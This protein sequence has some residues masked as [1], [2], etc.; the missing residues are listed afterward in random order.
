MGDGSVI[1]EGGVYE[2]GTVITLA[3]TPAP[4]WAFLKWVGT[5]GDQANPTSVHMNNNKNVLAFFYPSPSIDPKPLLTGIAVA[6]L[7]T[8]TL[9]MLS[10]LQAQDKLA[11]AALALVPHAK[12][13]ALAY[14]A[15][16]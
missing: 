10:R 13:L 8:A 9:I 15:A 14:G 12:A 2:D 11:P 6:S 1:P 7:L 16:Q 4:G 3:A 5:D